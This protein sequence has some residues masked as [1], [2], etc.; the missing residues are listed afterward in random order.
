MWQAMRDMPQRKLQV[1]NLEWIGNLYVNL[2]HRV[3]K[4]HSDFE[5]L[6]EI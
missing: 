2:W 6:K 3:K 4:E 1:E 5:I